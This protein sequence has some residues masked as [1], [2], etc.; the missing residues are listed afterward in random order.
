LLWHGRLSADLGVMT[1]ADD[2]PVGPG[3]GR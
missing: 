2:T 1:L 3:I